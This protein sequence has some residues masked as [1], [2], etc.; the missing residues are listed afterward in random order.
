MSKEII[1]VKNNYTPE[2]PKINSSVLE[3]IASKKIIMWKKSFLIFVASVMIISMLLVLLGFLIGHFIYNENNPQSNTN[4]NK[5]EI[6][7]PAQKQYIIRFG[8]FLNK[9][10]AESFRKKVSESYS[11]DVFIIKDGDTYHVISNTFETY[12]SAKFI[13]SSSKSEYGIYAAIDE[14]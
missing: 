6:I 13:V 8:S 1:W 14:V 12:E 3:E 11:C 9:S 4:Q 5:T 10:V 2:V 7:K